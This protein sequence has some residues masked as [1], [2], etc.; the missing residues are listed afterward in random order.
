MWS[1]NL[2]NF[3][4]LLEHFLR[5]FLPWHEPRVYQLVDPLLHIPG[6][7]IQVLILLLLQLIS[8]RGVC[9]YYVFLRLIDSS[10]LLSTFVS[11]LK[12][13]VLR[14]CLLWVLVNFSYEVLISHDVIVFFLFLHLCLQMI[15]V[16]HHCLLR[17]VLCLVVICLL[18]MQISTVNEWVFV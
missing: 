13:I 8:H 6:L 9:R 7:F 16:T 10:C 17:L 3:L 2:S 18:Y 11:D 15:Q 1:Y 4:N 14:V 12:H 5:G